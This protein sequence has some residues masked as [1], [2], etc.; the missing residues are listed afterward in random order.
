MAENEDIMIEQ[1][2]EEQETET[3]TTEEAAP[4]KTPETAVKTEKKPEKTPAKNRKNPFRSKKFKRGSLS[5]VFTVLFIAGIV[6]VN[7]VL[8]LVLERFN[9]EADLTSGSIFT[10]SDETVNYVSGLDDSISFFVT[11]DKDELKGAGQLY[12]QTVEFL[13]KMVS[14]NSRF[15][16]KYVNLLQDPDFTNNYVE[17]LQN[18]Q[19]IVQSE[20]TGRYRILSIND[21]MQYKLNDGK[22]YSYSEA[23]MYVNYGGYTVSDYSS[24]AEEQ[25]VSAI[26]SV[27]LD[28][29]TVVTFVKG[30]GESDS[31]ALEKILTNNAYVVQNAEIE[32]IEAV[33]EDTD[34]LVIHGPTKDYS[35]DSITKIDTWL[36]NDGKYGKDLIYIATPD[37]AETP[38]LDEYLK[39]W[40]I[41]VGRGYVLQF[42][43]DH[44]YYTGSALPV[45]QDI[46]MNTETAY[47][48]IMKKSSGTSFIGYYVRP[49]IKLWEN[50]GNL[51]NVSVAS[52]YGEKCIMFPFTAD[53]SWTPTEDSFTS[54]DV[55][56]E[57]SKVQFA[58]NNQPT[59]SKVIVCG[60][61]QL[62]TDYFTTASNY[63]NG[64]AALSLF[65]AN[66]DNTGKTISIVE[67][68]FAAETYQI[69][70]GTQA[71]IGIT[72][73]IVIPVVIIIIGIVVWI[74]RRRL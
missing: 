59:Y 11:A 58:D 15:K 29:P 64:E 60:S 56:V 62:F 35:L 26:M 1:T 4:E 28:D 48:D 32:R 2:G 8:N 72:F 24:T 9:V 17:T 46:S 21:F 37:P 40:G 18:Y 47:Y 61:D 25:L 65:D 66:S 13:D 31:S 44:A 52:A 22:T 50:E 27:S 38:N 45:M 3:V 55:I 5:V 73:A 74:R 20:K 34:I 33:P 19:V 6:L 53:E 7:I 42:D 30:Y 67:K 41:E 51:A 54:Y 10:L 71:A 36:S 12:A 43:T 70:R 16:V 57:A 23:S 49:V 63:S 69:D 14:L 68:S 39:E